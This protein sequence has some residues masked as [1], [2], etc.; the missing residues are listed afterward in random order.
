MS[1]QKTVTRSSYLAKNLGDFSDR[2]KLNG[3]SSQKEEDLRYGTNPYQTAAYYK[4][5]EISSP[6]GD[7]EILKSGKDGLFLKP[8]I[9]D[10]PYALNNA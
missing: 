8:T 1:K 7:M 5:V 10:I 2:I 6:I 3:I 4:P 9:E